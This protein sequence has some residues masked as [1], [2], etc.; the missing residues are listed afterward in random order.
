MKRLA[1]F[2]LALAAVCLMPS[3]K[4]IDLNEQIPQ[5]KGSWYW[6][7][8]TIGGGIGNIYADTPNLVLTFEDDNKISIDCNDERLFESET[9]TVCKS[10]NSIL[11]DYII[12]MPKKIQAKV[13]ECVGLP[14]GYIMMNGY[15]SV[16]DYIPEP[17]PSSRTKRLVFI[18][19]KEVDVGLEGGNYHKSSMFAPT[20]ELN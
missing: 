4:K 11:G 3:C 8:S 6:E 9:Y 10:N 18:D 7:M 13:A 15:V 17:D 5:L 14:E 1:L 12:T 16:I 20:H 2:A 19:K